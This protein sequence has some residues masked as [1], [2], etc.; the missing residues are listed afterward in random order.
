MQQRE[1]KRLLKKLLHTTAEQIFQPNFDRTWAKTIQFIFTN[2]GLYFSQ[3]ADYYNLSYAY[4][5]T[6]HWL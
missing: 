4:V 3:K 5:Y 6:E 1:N 2:E